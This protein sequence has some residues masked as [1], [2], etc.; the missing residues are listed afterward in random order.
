MRQIKIFVLII[1]GTL[2]LVPAVL[3]VPVIQ[4]NSSNHTVSLVSLIAVF[5]VLPFAFIWGMRLSMNPLRRILTD[6]QRENIIKTPT[7]FHNESEFI[8][9]TFQGLLSRLQNQQQELERLNEQVNQR[10]ESAEKLSERIVA[11][12][13]SGLIAFDKKG[14]VSLFNL[15]AQELLD[16]SGELN[17]KSYRKIFAKT[18]VLTEMLEKSLAENVVF[19]R[20][21]IIFHSSNLQEPKIFGVT[22]APIEFSGGALLLFSDLTE[23]KQL[24]EQLAIK[25]NLESLGEMSAGLAHEFK[26]SL[27]ALQ[28][29]A[30]LFQRLD[31][32]ERGNKA[33]DSLLNE[34][35]HLSS[36]ITAFLD[37]S[38]PNQLNLQEFSLQDLIEDCLDELSPLFEVRGI[39]FRF[40][41][42]VSKIWGDELLLRQT[43][44]NLL[45]NAAEAIE[46]ETETKIISVQT[47]NKKTKMAVIKIKDSGKGIEPENI[48]KIFI[49]FFTTKNNGHGIG[50]A[51]A[52]RVITQHQ[53]TLAVENSKDGGAEFTVVLP[54][55]KPN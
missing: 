46:D 44:L 39:E 52:H 53:G 41:G 55:S 3:F 9:E 25:R 30:Q 31:L 49:P 27:A 18:P 43:F 20:E 24:R 6:A 48:S 12:L 38:R 11:S 19:R 2:V 14:F 40:E 10:A 1:I 47:I 34:T 36:M 7:K 5:I 23:I 29:Y 45:R 15:S 22:I 32:D 37:F 21:D 28:S 33:A 16:Q 54:I 51:L 50:L 26:N 13:P 8:V 17:G 42:K 4:L 35:R